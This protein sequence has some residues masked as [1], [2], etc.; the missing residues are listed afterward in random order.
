MDDVSLYYEAIQKAEQK[1]Q[2]LDFLRESNKIEGI[3]S[4]PTENQIIAFKGFLD[5]DTITIDD[6]ISLVSIFQPDA[7]FRDTHGL[8][9]RVGSYTPPKG[10]PE[11]RTSLQSILN[12]TEN[13]TPWG[14]HCR[15][16][17]LHPFTDGNG[18]SGRMLW[19]WMMKGRHPLGFLHT[20]YYQTLAAK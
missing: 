20:F 16:E 17:S 1:R 3:S 8:N 11:I 15:Y 6:L 12:D 5:K 18:R 10:S 7:Y 9:V 2:L 13:D 4:P 19:S 14:I